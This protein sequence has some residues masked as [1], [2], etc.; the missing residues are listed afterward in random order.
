M[1]RMMKWRTLKVRV[2]RRRGVGQ[3]ETSSQDA[4]KRKQKSRDRA[5]KRMVKL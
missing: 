1:K 2:K 5:G 3:R 4:N